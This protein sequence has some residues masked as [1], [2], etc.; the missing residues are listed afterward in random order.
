MYK[1]CKKNKM[2]WKGVIFIP[3]QELEVSGEQL[4]PAGLRINLVIVHNPSAAVA[5][6]ACGGGVNCREKSC[7][8]SVPVNILVSG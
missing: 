1:V 5:V 7:V 3:E 2:Y 4:Y 6:K 8:K